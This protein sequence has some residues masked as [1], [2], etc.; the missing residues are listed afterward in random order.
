MSVR[1]RGRVQDYSS[2][3]SLLDI[4]MRQHLSCKYHNI[5][6]RIRTRT[7]QIRHKTALLDNVFLPCGLTIDRIP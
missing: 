4:L 6:V 1:E 5:T 3:Q 2:P 7:A